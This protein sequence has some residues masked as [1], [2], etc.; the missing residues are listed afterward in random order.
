[1]T[2]NGCTFCDLIGELYAKNH[3]LRSG[4][5]VYNLKSIGFNAYGIEPQNNAVSYA[6]KEGLN[7]FS[8]MFPDDISDNV[9]KDGYVLISFLQS[10]YY[11]TN[12]K[13]I[14]E[15]AS[16]MLSEGGYLL[17]QNICRS[18]AYYDDKG[19]SFFERYNDY[20]QVIPTYASIQYWLTHSG[21]EIEYMNE[22]PVLGIN[23]HFKYEGKYLKVFHKYFGVFLD[24]FH[25]LLFRN[26]ASADKLII[27]AKQIR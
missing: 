1:L 17:I 20:V 9:P 23:K 5:F 22:L 18:S 21:F 15:N 26:L 19:V 13:K 10:I 7:V 16:E 11:T 2:A 8:G 3:K 25:K 4:G 14:F 6:Q 12:L 27:I 24:F